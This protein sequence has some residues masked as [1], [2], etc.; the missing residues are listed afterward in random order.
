MNSGDNHTRHKRTI[1]KALTCSRPSICR[2][3]S[4][5]SW[6][7]ATAQSHGFHSSNGKRSNETPPYTPKIEDEE[8]SIHVDPET[9][10][11]TTSTDTLPVSPF[12]DPSFHEA[13]RRYTKTKPPPFKSPY[14]PT[15]FQRILARNPYGTNPYLLHWRQ[16]YRL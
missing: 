6:Q 2:N 8:Y 9:K 5:C 15:K 13:R 7:A 14:K 16:E 12:M 1:M 11:V 10:T 4:C 3:I